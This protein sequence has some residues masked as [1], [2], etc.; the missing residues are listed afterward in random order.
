MFG[1]FGALEVHFSYFICSNQQCSPA[2]QYGPAPRQS[3]PRPP[4]L[5]LVQ[6]P[7]RCD[8]NPQPECSTP[9]LPLTV[10]PWASPRRTMLTDVVLFQPSLLADRTAPHVPRHGL[11]PCCS[12][13]VKQKTLSPLHTPLSP[14]H[15]RRSAL[16]LSR[17]PP[18]LLCLQPARASILVCH[19]HPWAMPQLQATGRQAS[20]E[21]TSRRL[22]LPGPLSASTW[23]GRSNHS[24]DHL[25]PPRA[26]HRR[27]SAHRPLHRPPQTLL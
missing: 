3:G 22:P 14:I 27:P 12:P 6:G 5:N 15:F 2:A 10:L 9:K 18:V 11:I 16:P 13:S 26:A 7:P 23:M 19:L 21:A 20:V 8:Q 25:P 17:C 24:P 4:W 1:I